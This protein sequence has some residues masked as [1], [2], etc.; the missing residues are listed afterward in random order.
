MGIADVWEKLPIM[1]GHWRHAKK[2]LTMYGDVGI[3]E[4]QLGLGVN[5]KGAE[6]KKSVRFLPHW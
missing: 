6:E 4:L 3:F 1:H 2:L 5:V